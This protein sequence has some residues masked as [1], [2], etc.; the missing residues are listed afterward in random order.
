M[1]ESRTTPVLLSGIQPSGNLMIGNYIGAL[2]NWV[3]LQEEYDCLFVLV[4]LHS[5]TVKQDPAD[6]RRRCY[7]F[8]CLYLACGI[9]PEKNTIFVQCNFTDGDRC[10][11]QT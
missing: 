4:D 2:G 6:L 9:D 7:E 5:I 11:L 8:L 1:T 10:S 3:K